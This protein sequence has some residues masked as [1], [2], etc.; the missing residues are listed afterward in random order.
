[1]LTGDALLTQRSISE[2]IIKRG[3][4]YLFVVK[5][6]QPQLLEDIEMSFADYW[7][8]RDTISE[9]SLTDQHGNRT[10]EWRLKVSTILEGYSNWPGLK[11]VLKLERVVSN[12]KSGEVRREVSYAIT[13]LGVIRLARES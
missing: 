9:G 5:D 2:S 7:W 13:S 12:K 3:G 10:H 1:V 11:Q 8:L 6:N 4:D